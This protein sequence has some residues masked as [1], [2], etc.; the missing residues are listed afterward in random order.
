MPRSASP[1]VPDEMGGGIVLS[2]NLDNYLLSDR[3]PDREE[4]GT[5]NIV[6][7]AY[8]NNFAG[9]TTVPPVESVAS[10]DA[11]S[12]CTWKSGITRSETSL[13]DRS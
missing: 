12:P 11:T 7:A 5:P 3:L 2:V 8:T 6:G 13:G 9:T 4:A 1:W 10:V